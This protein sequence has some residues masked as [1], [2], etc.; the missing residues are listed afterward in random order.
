MPSA[1]LAQALTGQC[2]PARAVRSSDTAA[3]GPFG[4]SIGTASG[5]TR[6]GPLS[7]QDVPL[8]QQG[9]HPTDAGADGDAEALG[10]DL[11][12]MP[13]SAQASREATRAYWP[14]GSLRRTS[15]LDRV[16]EVGVSM[17][18]AN[19]TG[20]SCSSSHSWVQRL[21]AGRAGQDRLPR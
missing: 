6:R 16:C 1:P 13:A 21:G 9:P 15:T 10:V 4:I 11:T 3:A 5:N 18:A 7:A 19:V 12:A 14:A 2:A 8:V 20:R 17:L